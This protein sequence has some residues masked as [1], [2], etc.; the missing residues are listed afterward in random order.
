MFFCL[1]PVWLSSF[2]PST[3][4]KVEGRSERKS[5]LSS[6]CIFYPSPTICLTVHF[7]CHHFS[8]LADSHLD[9]RLIFFNVNQKRKIF[10]NKRLLYVATVTLVRRKTIVFVLFPWTPS[11]VS[12]VTKCQWQNQ[13][14]AHND[15]YICAFSN[16]PL[17]RFS[18][19]KNHSQFILHAFQ[20]SCAL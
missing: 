17:I 18:V 13:A 10:L 1:C 14:L 3:K 4:D 8:S 9:V 20:L 6:A 7:E 19:T 15:S 5:S 16:P 2:L 12:M 11:I